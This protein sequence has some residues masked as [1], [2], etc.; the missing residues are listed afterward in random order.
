MP[1]GG[2]SHKGWLFYWASTDAG[3][4]ESQESPGGNKPEPR[5]RGGKCG[6]MEDMGGEVLK[7]WE[8]I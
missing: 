7:G 2:K 1:Q 4:V 3:E 5:R 6:D 8:F